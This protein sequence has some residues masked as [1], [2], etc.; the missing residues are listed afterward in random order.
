MPAGASSGA[1]AADSGAIVVH[2]FRAV[3][4]GAV[5]ALAV[6]VGVLAAPAVASAER[7]S[8][9]LGTAIGD[10]RGAAEVRDGYDRDLFKHWVDADGDGCDT[11]DEVLLAESLDPVTVG[12]SCSLSGGRWYSYYDRR[13]WTDSGRI[14]IDHLVP[15]AEAWDSGAR[16]WTARTRERYANDLG[17]G[18]TLVGV[19]DSVNQSKGD[20]DPAEWMPQHGTCRYVRQWVAVKHRWRLGVDRAERRALRSL[21]AG[22]GTARIT[23]TLAR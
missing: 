11:R 23:V 8:A 13:T 18:R 22:C 10:L 6:L 1:S 21:A 15:L 19:T 20:Q 7:Y 2:R 3:L 16:T 12:S 5:L 9:P 4:T 14:D 17:D